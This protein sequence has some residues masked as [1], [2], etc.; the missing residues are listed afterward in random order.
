MQEL[1]QSYEDLLEK[2]QKQKEQLIQLYDE[3]NK[4]RIELRSKIDTNKSILTTL[5]KKT[6]DGFIYEVPVGEANLGTTGINNFGKD[7]QSKLIPVDFSSMLYKLR[8]SIV[9]IHTRNI[10]H[11]EIETKPTLSLLN[12]SNCRI[13]IIFAIAFCIESNFVAWHDRR[14]KCL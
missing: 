9:E 10:R 12:V 5:R 2:E 14:L 4:G 6:T 1:E 11:G 8:K 13:N 3:Q 7:K